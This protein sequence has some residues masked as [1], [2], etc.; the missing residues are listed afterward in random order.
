MSDA[1]NTSQRTAW[2]RGVATIAA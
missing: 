1:E 2:G